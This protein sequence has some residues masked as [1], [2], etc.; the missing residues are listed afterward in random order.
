MA[1]QRRLYRLTYPD[2]KPR[3]SRLQTGV[4][5]R[6]L[7]ERQARHMRRAAAHTKGRLVSVE[8]VDGEG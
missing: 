6:W 7:T 5:E 1:E 8:L 3:G 4:V 2:S